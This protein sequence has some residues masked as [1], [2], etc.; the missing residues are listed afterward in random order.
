MGVDLARVA[1]V[2]ATGPTGSRFGSAYL[3]APGRV[4]T[5]AH[6]LVEAGLGR[7]DP[8][9]I[10]PSGSGEWL[11][12]K[13]IWLD[14]PDGADAA[15]I[16]L[17]DIDRWP[18]PTTIVR[19]G[20]IGGSE[21][22]QAAAVGY[23]W[24]QERPDTSRDTEHVIGFVPPGTGQNTQ[25][26]HLT[27]QSSPPSA[28][29]D[30]RS[31]WAGMSGA[32]LIAGHH[33]VGCLVVDPARYGTDRLVAVPTQR[34]LAAPGFVDALG[35]SPIPAGIG[36]N[37]RLQYGPS[38]DQSL[39]MAAAYRAL[40][41]R[42]EA[43]RKAPSR[44]LRPSLG[45]V[46]FTGRRDLVNR[47]ATWSMERVPRPGLAVHTLTGG[48]GS[49]KSRLAAEVCSTITPRGWD[50]GI[51]DF[52][53]PGGTV[54]FELDRPSLI[55]VDDAD[56]H[57]TQIAKLIRV[58][59][60][61]SVPVRLLLLA[62]S[63][64][65][66]WESLDTLTH[67]DLQGYDEGDLLLS[68]YPLDPSDRFRHYG[69]A[70][71]AFRAA[72]TGVTASSSGH[73]DVPPSAL[74]D[75][76]FADPLLVHLAALQAAADDPLVLSKPRATSSTR[77]HVL[78]AY[79]SRESQRW[80]SL[81]ATQ[82]PPLAEP[83]EVLRRSVALACLSNPRA[84]TA[85]TAE[86][87][88]AELLSFI[89]DISGESDTSRRFRL[90]RWLHD[91][92]S[93]PEYW[94]PLR[95][96]PLADQLLAKIDILPHLV[97]SLLQFSDEPTLDRL[98]AELVRAA[99]AV[100]G[101]ADQAL[102]DSVLGQLDKALDAAIARPDGPIP[103]RL[104]VALRR[105]PAPGAAAVLHT[106]LPSRSL[107][108][109]DLAEQITSQAVAHYRELATAAQPDA[110]R[111]DLALVLNDQ[112][113]RLAALGR[114]EDARMAID[115]AVTIFRDLATAQPDAYRPNLAAALNDQSNRLSALGR[116]EDALTATDEALTIYGGLATAQPDAY[117]PD[118]AAGLSNQSSWLAALGRH[119]DALT[120][121]DKALTIF[122]DLATAQP[123]AYRPDIAGVLN[124]QS[125]RLSALGR[126]KDALTAVDEALTI[127]RDLATAQPDAYRPDLA[128][129]LGNQSG[130]L[131]ALGRHEDALMA[132]DKALTIYRDL[133]TA[134]PDAYRPGLAM[135][136]LNRSNRL[137]ALGRLEDAVT[138]F[139][140]AVTI[141]RYLATARPAACRPDLAMALGSQSGCLAALGRHQAALTATDEALTI[142]RGL[143][144]ARPDAH[145]PG[146]AMVLYNRSAVL[147]ALG[148]HEG[149]L[150]ATDEAL[151]I[152]RDLATARPDAYHP[153]LAM[154][155]YNRSAGLAALGRLDD[156]LTAIDEALTIYRD[157][158]TVRP[159]AFRPY[160]ALA[161][162]VKATILHGLGNRWF[163]W[164]LRRE[165][166]RIS[167]LK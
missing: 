122:R 113:N 101:A 147:G 160:V 55:V 102:A 128:M 85:A 86:A 67:H 145:R 152:Y 79:L 87:K 158:A 65:A 134:Q 165:A 130:C 90:A 99:A 105:T 92:H 151:T 25:R 117:R 78:T 27:I 143:A 7:G 155:L 123:D 68:Q 23:P 75:D 2:Y 41:D 22:V 159:D 12:A 38:P 111:P 166:N 39:S 148:R 43:L 51:A 34:I 115:E 127:Y 120:A 135:A 93:G 141:Y 49:G 60:Y 59:S 64:T 81:A 13:I 15:L 9:E 72:L 96:D 24:A 139:D 37:W 69:Q 77:D 149:A 71:I 91:L 144:T 163:A 132:S 88:A 114:H 156:A 30:G 52:E 63:R 8:A 98:F 138:A 146:L 126:H 14:P 131:A 11:P 164:R 97:G 47:L 110:F 18:S 42:P 118:I 46:P 26:H 35:E 150:T 62:R 84:D 129:A 103:Q 124:D 74:S 82:T 94:N 57:V 5:A 6:V 19:W 89:P 108:L 107:A 137:S 36:T 106:R 48:G 95:P 133:A 3:V 33:L 4:L 21:P 80:Q 162:R 44:L 58:L 1:A 112:S 153:D 16:E 56:L 100:G 83:V 31:P 140:E 10:S 121:I 142:Y 53:T 61:S 161:I 125:I 45:V 50:A 28:R 20:T 109:A 54:Q 116:H 136:L 40:P 157:L 104:L 167:R 76:A 70:L 154:A 73:T 29:P 119:E 66:W 17:Q 32:A